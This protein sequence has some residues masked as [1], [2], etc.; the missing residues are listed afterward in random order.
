[1]KKDEVTQALYDIFRKIEESRST[2][3]YIKLLKV[4]ITETQEEIELSSDSP[5]NHI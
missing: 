3:D 5:D 4:I 2:A 1:M